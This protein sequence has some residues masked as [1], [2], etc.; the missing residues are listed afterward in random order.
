MTE[1]HTYCTYINFVLGVI[2]IYIPSITGKT[3]TTQ[4][5]NANKKNNELVD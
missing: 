3:V 5:I 4:R 2:H 1:F